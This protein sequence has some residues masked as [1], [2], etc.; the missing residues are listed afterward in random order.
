MDLPGVGRQVISAGSPRASSFMSLA[1]LARLGPAIELPAAP[2]E[3]LLIFDCEGY[4]TTRGS[5]HVLRA[6]AVDTMPVNGSPASPVALPLYLGLWP[7][8]W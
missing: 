4:V 5:V 2:L 3:K 8:S 6:D 7:R 1:K